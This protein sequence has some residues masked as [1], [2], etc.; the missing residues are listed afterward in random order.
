VEDFALTSDTY[1]VSQNAARI[2]RGL[3]EIAM[4]RNWGPATSVILS[5]C[6]S[7]DKRLWSFDP[8]LMQFDLPVDISLKLES[9]PSQMSIEHIREMDDVEVGKLIRNQ[10]MGAQLFKYANN[11]PLLALE[12][13]VAPITRSVLRV[14]LTISADFNW[15]DRIH[16]YAEPFW[17]WVEDAENVDI[18]YSEYFIM[19]KM[20]LMQPQEIQFT[21]PLLRTE[22]TVDELPPQVFIRAISDRWISSETVLPVSFKHL[23]LPEMDRSEYTDLLDLQPLPISALKDAL[24]EEIC[25]KRFEYF[26]PIQTQVFHTLYHTKYNALIGAPT[27]SGKTV[28][29]ELAMW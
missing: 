15:N 3:F 24:L 28:V 11:F 4:S 21:I 8:P 26:N 16:G 14:N 5:L 20:Q 18:L 1:Y 27:G 29:A 23:I 25:R 9:L 7:V 2:L 22:S 19:T 10:K 6:K 17:I 12:A 13:E